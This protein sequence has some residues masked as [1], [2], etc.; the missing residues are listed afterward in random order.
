[1]YGCDGLR[2]WLITQGF[3]CATAAGLRSS[4]CDW[5]AHRKSTLPA[6]ECEC[7]EGKT[8]QLVVHPFTSLHQ[9]QRWESCEVDLTGQTGGLWFKLSAYSLTPNELYEQ[10]P[11]IEAMLVAAWNALNPTP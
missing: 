2:D 8:I 10:L 4:G 11:K 9:G 1:M 3:T 6:R 5:Y 7:N